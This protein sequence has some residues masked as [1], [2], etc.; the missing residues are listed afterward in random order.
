MRFEY[1]LTICLADPEFKKY[2]D[3]DVK[4][5]NVDINFNKNQYEELSIGE[6]LTLLQDI[7]LDIIKDKGIKKNIKYST[8]IIFFEKKIIGVR[9]LSFYLILE[10]KN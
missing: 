9:L 5:S 4:L 3:E 6:V 2:W 8:D 1:F 10:I 7:Y